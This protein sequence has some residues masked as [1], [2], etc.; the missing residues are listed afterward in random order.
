[1][2]NNAFICACTTSFLFYFEIALRRATSCV[3]RSSSTSCSER[4][5]CRCESAVNAP[6]RDRG[7]RL[8]PA[9]PTHPRSRS[10]V[11]QR[12][13]SVAATSTTEAPPFTS[14]HISRRLRPAFHSFE[15]LCVHA[16][17]VPA[18]FRGN[19]AQRLVGGH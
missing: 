5:A 15:A 17:D 13:Q 7:S 1:M 14:A 19:A 18:T 11:S 6:G 10:Q 3:F 9:W 12:S 2:S 8:A 16:A 4:L